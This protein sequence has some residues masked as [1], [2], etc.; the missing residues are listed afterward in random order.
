MESP[1]YMT[2]VKGSYTFSNLS[3]RQKFV[4]CA[5]ILSNKVFH[6]QHLE[7]SFDWMNDI[8][9][10]NTNEV[11]DYEKNVLLETIDSSELPAVPC[12]LCKA[13]EDV[14]IK[15]SKT[16]NLY[17][18]NSYRNSY[19][20]FVFIEKGDG[21]WLHSGFRNIPVLMPGHEDM[22]AHKLFLDIA[23]IEPEE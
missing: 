9:E 11:L 3:Q 23:G 7:F 20:A 22:N 17:V 4:L 16:T 15:N 8:I 14:T 2:G 5:S 6:R 12:I 1:D 13:V 19:S 18:T 21:I 10:K